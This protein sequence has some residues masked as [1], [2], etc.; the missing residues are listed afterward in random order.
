MKTEELS[1]K[2]NIKK[3]FKKLKKKSVKSR[4]NSVK[5]WLIGT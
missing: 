3:I 4:L 2:Q 1:L 5:K